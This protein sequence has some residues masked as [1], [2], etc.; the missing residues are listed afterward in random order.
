MHTKSP[1]VKPGDANFT[2]SVCVI[3]ELKDL[4]LATVVEKKKGRPGNE[5][6]KCVQPLS[7]LKDNN[8]V[9]MFFNQLWRYA[10]GKPTRAAQASFQVNS[11][12]ISRS[13]VMYT[14]HLQP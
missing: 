3:S 6:N 13:H 2:A 9:F 10:S 5:A 11:T 1:T 4:N 8:L 7:L 14:R 12:C